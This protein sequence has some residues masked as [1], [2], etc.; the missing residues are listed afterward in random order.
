MLT[1]GSLSPFVAISDLARARTFYHEKLGLKVFAEDEGHVSLDCGGTRL[2]IFHHP[3]P[4][5]SAR[6][7]LTWFVRDITRT[8]KSL[9]DN[10]V[11]FEKYAEGPFKTDSL[12]IAKGEGGRPSAAWFKDPDGHIIGVMQDT[13]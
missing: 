11:T 9:T 3:D 7:V 13:E 6:T 10:G 1:G 8:V 12:G 4:Q 2:V 5:A